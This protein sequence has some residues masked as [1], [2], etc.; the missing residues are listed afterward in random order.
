MRSRQLEQRFRVVVSDDCRCVGGGFWSTKMKN[1]HSSAPVSVRRRLWSWQ[2]HL[3]QQNAEAAPLA[4]FTQVI[5]C[6]LRVHFD[7]YSECYDF[8]VNSNSA[9]IRPAG[10][11]HSNKRRLHP[12]KGYSESDFD[13]PLYLQSTGAQAAPPS[14]FT[15]HTAS[16]DFHVGMKLEAVDKK[17]P[18]LVCV[19]SVADVVDDRVLV[20]FDNWDNSYDYWCESSSPL[21]R[22]V[23]WCEKH[24][25]ALTAPHAHPDP[26]NFTWEEYLRETAL[27]AAPRSAFTTRALHGFQINQRLEA[28]DKRNPMLIRV[29]TV[30]ATE[31]Y[32]VKVHY[33]G[34]SPQL[35]VWCDSDLTDLHP[36]GWCQRTGHPLEVPPER[37]TS[38]SHSQGVCPTPGCRGVGHIKGPKYTGHHSAFGCPY[39]DINTRKEPLLPDRL[40][41]VTIHHPGNQSEGGGAE[42]KTDCGDSLVSP[43]VKRRRMTDRLPRTTKL[44]PV[45][46]QEEELNIQ[47]CGPEVLHQSVFLSAMSAPPTCW[48]QHRKL[49]P[50]VT[51]VHSNAVRHWS[52]QQVCAFVESLPGCEDLAKQFSDEQIDGRAF[53]LLTQRDIIT[54]MSIK[55]GP[56]LKIYNS[57]LML[58]HDECKS[59]DED[60]NQLDYMNKKQSLELDKT[61]SRDKDKN[62]LHEDIEKKHEI[63]KNQSDDEY[64]NQSHDMDKNQSGDDDK[65]QKCETDE[66]QSDDE[67]ENQSHDMDKKQSGHEDIDQK[68]EIDKSQSDDECKNQSHDMDKNQSGHDD[69]A[70]KFEID[71]HQSDDENENQSHDMDKKQ[72]GHEDIDQK[73]EIDKSQS[74]DDCKNQSHDMD[75]NQSGHED[76]A[77]KFEIDEH[78]SDDEDENQSHDMGKKQSGHEDIDQKHEIDKS[79]S[80]DDCKNQ[81]HDMVKNQSGHEDK[82]PKFEIDKHQSDDDENQS[83]MDKNQ[84]GHEDIDQKHEVDKN[85]SGN[86]SYDEDKNQ[87]VDDKNQ[88]LEEEPIS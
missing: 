72:S 32:R 57:I 85:Q 13:W 82:A 73:H 39:S 54:I 31:D 76:K 63:D 35:D 83:L 74:D 12:P 15:R 51:K 34:W 6:R 48:E 40:G 1:K 56:A 86:Q 60:K 65:A 25:R 58:K 11:C 14:L 30:T 4:L 16:C 10:W 55:L 8:W 44:L 87:P 59:R 81:S 41:G 46:Q 62:Q 47:A 23:G 18:G 27:E 24:G 78:Q 52:V 50:G 26:E 67:N 7:G 61:Q 21:I 2:Q 42:V 9:D 69:K 33:D 71:V 80:D 77:Q 29:A 20:H 3:N 22:P 36:V 88:S 68:D 5:G 37:S 19:A 43:V 28:V 17:N 79:Q 84:L 49:L 70:Q 75:K 64:K 66:H 38:P 53:L 45:K